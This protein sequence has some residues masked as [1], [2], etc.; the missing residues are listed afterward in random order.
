MNYWLIKT[1]PGTYSWDDLERDGQTFWDG[2]R[3]YQ[4]RN[5]LKA[6]KTGDLCLFYHSVKERQV[7]GIAEVVKEHYQDPSTDD[8]RW[9]SV[10]VKK[11]KKLKTPVS[12]DAIKKDERL[13]DMVLVKNS[14]LSVQPVKRDEF[15]TILGMAEQEAY[16]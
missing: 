8:E 13:T 16:K 7:I 10:D 4:A 2:V 14:R 1:E 9:L 3:N 15:D 5:N 6:M 12:L 11:Y